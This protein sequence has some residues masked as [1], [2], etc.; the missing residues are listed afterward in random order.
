MSQKHKFLKPLLIALTALIVVPVSARLLYLYLGPP[1]LTPGADP[2]QELK[3]L[4][5]ALRTDS[6]NCSKQF[7]N[8]KDS[9][10]VQNRF[11]LLAFKFFFATNTS[12]YSECYYELAMHNLKD[13]DLASLALARAI[14]LDQGWIGEK[15]VGVFAGHFSNRQE[16]KDVCQS[17]LFFNRKFALNQLSRMK[18][19]C[20]DP[21]LK[22]HILAT[23]SYA[24]NCAN[25]QEAAADYAEKASKLISEFADRISSSEKNH[26]ERLFLGA[27][28]LGQIAPEI[29]GQ[30]QTGNTVRL[31]DFKKKVVFLDFWGDW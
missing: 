9:V 26:L 25:N 19:E 12:K 22:A 21:V 15:A 27:G 3:R 18:N 20:Q 7:S 5:S 4:D 28:T 30:I 23:L 10:G 1:I 2:R 29:V 24:L 31:S 11:F 13:A 16:T 6:A 8:L 14:R 17:L